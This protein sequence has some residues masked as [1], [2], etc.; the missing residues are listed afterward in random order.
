MNLG[1]VRIER[2]RGKPLSA[3]DRTL[4]PVV[5][6]LSVR[7]RHGTVR[8]SSIEGRGGGFVIAWPIGVIEQQRGAEQLIRI[9]DVTGFALW[10]IAAVACLVSVA[11]IVLITA[12]H[13][14]R[15]RAQDVH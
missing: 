10:I 6:V 3:F 4:V 9:R 1:P 7:T 13:S 12:N 5:G 14:A 15:R 11:A 2:M 8:H